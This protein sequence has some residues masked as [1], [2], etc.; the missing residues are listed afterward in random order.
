MCK[1]NGYFTVVDFE[2]LSDIWAFC[3]LRLVIRGDNT[4]AADNIL[5]DQPLGWWDAHWPGSHNAQGCYTND[6]PVNDTYF[7]VLPLSYAF[8]IFS[9]LTVAPFHLHPGSFPAQ[10]IAFM[11][12]AC[13]EAIQNSSTS[14]HF[15]SSWEV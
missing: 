4:G 3:V 10:A 12:H 5:Y 7:E 2:N 9:C 15:T 14:Q 8:Y 6:A 1:P 11:L 13:T